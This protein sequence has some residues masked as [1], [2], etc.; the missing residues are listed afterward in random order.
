MME[1][2]TVTAV[3][4]S[5][6]ET[7]PGKK[8]ETNPPGVARETAAMVERKEEIGAHT[9]SAIKKNQQGRKRGER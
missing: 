2:R 7:A 6:Y 4:G 8:R 9:N 1:A 3:G 5:R